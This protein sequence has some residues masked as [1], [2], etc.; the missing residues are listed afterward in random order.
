MAGTIQGQQTRLANRELGVDLSLGLT[1]DEVMHVK[2]TNRSDHVVKLWDIVAS[3]ER[4]GTEDQPQ[5][6]VGE[7]YRIAD[8]NTENAAYGAKRSMTSA[9]QQAEWPKL[10]D[11]FVFE[12]KARRVPEGRSEL[13]AGVVRT[14]DADG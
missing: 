2:P 10:A 8:F 5:A 12:I 13:W 7:L 4:D 11:G 1:P 14:G 6:R 3:I 9:A